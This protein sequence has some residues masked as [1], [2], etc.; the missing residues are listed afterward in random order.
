MVS[1]R[2][3]V[4][5]GVVTP[6]EGTHPSYVE[7]VSPIKLDKD[8]MDD[9]RRI[10]KRPV[11]YSAFALEMAETGSVKYD[12][13]DDR[14]VL[15]SVEVWRGYNSSL[16]V[17]GVEENLIRPK[18]LLLVGR[19]G[20]GLPALV[21]TPYR[22]SGNYIGDD[23]TIEMFSMGDSI[24]GNI[25]VVKPVSKAP[26]VGRFGKPFEIHRSSCLLIEMEY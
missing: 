9:F 10:V 20:R 5:K 16:N 4:A 12:I 24:K 7:K 14:G 26:I 8:A 17:C 25:V 6:F 19:D 1:R 21:K 11:K 23:G 2:P 15:G 13:Q 18:E 22:E 3:L